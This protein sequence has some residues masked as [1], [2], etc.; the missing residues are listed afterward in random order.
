MEVAYE[1]FWTATGIFLGMAYFGIL[2]AVTWFVGHI[3]Y[4]AYVDWRWHRNTKAEMEKDTPMNSILITRLEQ[5]AY[6][7]GF[8]DGKKSEADYRDH[9]S[10]KDKQ[11]DEP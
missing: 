1:A 10:R 3:A 9:L 6:N 8:T 4:D 5:Q 2:I 11:T 7:S